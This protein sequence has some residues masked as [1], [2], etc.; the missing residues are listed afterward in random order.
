MLPN[1]GAIPGSALRH[2]LGLRNASS[3]VESTN[4]ALTARRQKHNGMSGLEEGSHAMTALNRLVSNRCH[5]AWVRKQTIP[6][7][8]V[9]KAA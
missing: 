3:P 5:E 9:N 4:N 1:Q 8:F 2:Q 7:A 6:F